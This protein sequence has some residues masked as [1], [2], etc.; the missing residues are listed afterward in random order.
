MGLC[1]KCWLLL[2]G[3][4]QQQ[5][6]RINTFVLKQKGLENIMFCVQ[7]PGYVTWLPSVDLPCFM[8]M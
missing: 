1:Q 3:C 5:Q 6:Q 8:S 4:Q 2:A 7:F